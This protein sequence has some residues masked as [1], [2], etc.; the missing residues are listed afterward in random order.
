[1]EQVWADWTVTAPWSVVVPLLAL[2]H[3][4]V[5]LLARRLTLRV[6][7]PVL[8]SSEEG[9]MPRRT[10]QAL[11]RHG[12]MIVI[13]MVV[14]ALFLGLA[15]QQFFAQRQQASLVDCVSEWGADMVE[16]IEVRTT[17]SADVEK[18]T[19]NF[20][21]KS[22]KKEVAL[23]TIINTIILLRRNP[24]EAIQADLSD[25]LAMYAQAKIV[26]DRAAER[27]EEEQE[28]L[29]ETR[30]LNQYPTAPALACE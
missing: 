18:A 15:A 9:P 19:K 27:L 10:W 14:S 3:A 11:D 13:I 1:M 20:A 8:L 25:A 30:R 16:T 29:A 4:A 12:K 17:A 2:S 6:M 21:A 28:R 26:E 5:G 22:Q 7:A 24:P 23:D